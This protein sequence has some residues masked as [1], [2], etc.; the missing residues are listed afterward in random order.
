MGATCL[1]VSNR[2]H[3]ESQDVA[4]L[5]KNSSRGVLWLLAR[6]CVRLGAASKCCLAMVEEHPVYAGGC[7]PRESRSFRRLLQWA[8]CQY[9]SA[10]F[11][12]VLRALQPSFQTAVSKFVLCVD[13]IV[14]ATLAKVPV[15][16][17]VDLLATSF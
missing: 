12:W 1:H 16:F 4:S 17:A 6:P 9:I 3:L 11:L 14:E 8:A 2:I 7:E 10:A 5:L 15:R 13:C